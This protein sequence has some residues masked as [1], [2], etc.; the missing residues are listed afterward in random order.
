MTVEPG[1]VWMGNNLAK[2]LA[3]ADSST[4]MSWTHFGKT[5][6]EDIKWKKMR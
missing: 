2:W 5:G 3:A 6:F 4:V 1:K